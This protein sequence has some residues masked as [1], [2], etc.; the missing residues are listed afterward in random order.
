MLTRSDRARA[1][2][3]SRSRVAP[4]RGGWCHVTA[5]AG[6]LV[7]VA[8]LGAC[9][10]AWYRGQA[11][12]VA[13][14]IIEAGQREA[15][16]RTEPFTIETPADTLRRR[17]L[18]DQML[19]VKGP[20]SWGTDQLKLTEHWPEEGYPSRTEHDAG[21]IP[22]WGSDQPLVLAMLEALQV[23]AR[24]S[25]DYQSR[26]EDVFS[27]AMGLD[28]ELD[29]FR[30]TYTGLL[31]SLLSTDQSGGDS[32]T[33][34]ENMAEN[35]VTRRLRGGTILT[36]RLIIDLAK[37]LSSDRASSLGIFADASIA[38]PLLRGAGKHIVAEPLTQAQREVLYAIWSFER[39]KKT[40]AVAVASQY[41]SVLQ[42]RDQANNAANNY[43]RLIRSSHRA[44]R[45]RDAGRLEQIQ[46]DQALQDE[47]RARD[48][49]VSARESY[50]RGLDRF[51][52][53]LGLPT[54][55][56]VELDPTELDRLDE[57]APKS[58]GESWAKTDTSQRLSDDDPIEL[59][60]PQRGVGRM[61]MQEAEALRLA[62]E[63]RL[64]LRTLEG[65]VHD[66]QRRVVVAA[67]ALKAG[68]NLTGTV[69]AGE[70]RGLGSAGLPDAQLRPEHG[71]YSAGVD[72]DIPWERTAERNTYRDSFIVLE[73][74]ARD[75]QAQ[76]DQVKLDVRDRL[77]RLVQARESYA[78]QA[79]A[80]ALANERV[81]STNMFLE[82]GEAQIRDVLEAE[83]DLLDA[84]NAMT[85]AQVDYH[86]AELELQRD[87]GTLQVDS[88]GLWRE[89]D[90]DNDD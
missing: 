71:F 10:P 28:L 81:R 11:D 27:A 12:E 38:I 46:V 63:R 43:K 72:L 56:R 2:V 52:I 73:R 3:L 41:L 34:V 87:M 78:I 5:V 75:M 67:D 82:A 88:K 60:E 7:C 80:V 9:Q 49:W 51:K 58:L 64:D 57:T 89:F 70:R 66:A 20:A 55:A 48:N 68:L 37:L 35:T 59:V 90:H 17:L 42:L 24:N 23:G 14:R 61:E 16:G 26:K 44:R 30:N 18:A 13:S 86:V 84:Q 4:A 19:P 29:A 39:F 74:A 32:V 1:A 8:G 21:P 25:R 33:G 54:D 85:G 22:P 36:G 79:K 50:E 83:E 62:L 15:L 53:T 77:G 69:S 47:L 6:V 40:F 31:D 65:R 76:E 45:L